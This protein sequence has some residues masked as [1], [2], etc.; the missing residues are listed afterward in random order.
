MLYAVCSA[1]YAVCSV[2]YAVYE[3]CSVQYSEQTLC[4]MQQVQQVLRT[5]VGTV[6]AYS[7]VF[8]APWVVRAERRYQRRLQGVG[9]SRDTEASDGVSVS[10][11]ECS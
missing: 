6:F 7:T 11:G 9:V 3:L 1:R 4:C 2:Q 5:A 8:S 10:G